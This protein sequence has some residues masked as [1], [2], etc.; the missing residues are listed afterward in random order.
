MISGL[1]LLRGHQIHALRLLIQRGRKLAVNL[2]LGD[3][4][5]GQ[6]SA[7]FGQ[8]LGAFQRTFSFTLTLAVELISQRL[9]IRIQLFALLLRQ[10]R[11]HPRQLLAVVSRKLCQLQFINQCFKS[12]GFRL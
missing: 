4:A 9:E 6:V 11:T 7:V 1:T 5:V 3:D 12:G 10:F 2:K 8:Q